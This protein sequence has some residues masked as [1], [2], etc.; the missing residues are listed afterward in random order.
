M[1]KSLDELLGEMRNDAAFT[2]VVDKIMNGQCVLFTGS[3]FSYGANNVMDEALPLGDG[4]KNALERETGL[5][6]M[7]LEQAAEDYLEN[8]GEKSLVDFLR[9][10]FSIKK[11]SEAHI[12][13]AANKWKRIYTTNYDDLMEWAARQNKYVLT[14]VTPCDDV[15]ECSA[16]S[17]LVIHI[18]GS[19]HNLTP[20]AL[21]DEV[22]ERKKLQ[23]GYFSQIIVGPTI[24]LR[25]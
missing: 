12:E 9:T 25:P 18:N 5:Q 2:E 24:P 16:K 20:A 10:H 19:V 7:N 14:P 17:N 21:S 4:L 8:L 15:Q 1:A 13:A 11:G 22:V 6:A 23:S 3:G